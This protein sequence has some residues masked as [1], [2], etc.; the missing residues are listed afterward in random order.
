MKS[1]SN[2]LLNQWDYGLMHVTLSAWMAV[3]KHVFNLIPGMGG[4]VLSHEKSF[5]SFFYSL[6]GIGLRENERDSK[7][8]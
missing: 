7:Y 3:S 8:V 4:V 6:P 5:K 1:W 2:G